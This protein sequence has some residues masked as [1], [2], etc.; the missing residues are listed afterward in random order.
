VKTEYVRKSGLK[1]SVTQSRQPGFPPVYRGREIMPDGFY[2]EFLCEHASK[3]DPAD[4]DFVFHGDEDILAWCIAV[5]QESPL[6]RSLIEEVIATGWAF[7][8]DDLNNGGFHLDVERRLCRVDH[9]SLTP[10]ALSRSS[11]FRNSVLVSFVRALRDI[12]HED[13]IGGIESKLAPE[14]LIVLERLRS[15]DGDTVALFAGWELKGAGHADVW[16]YII[17]SD[18][19]DLAMVFSRFLERGAAALSGGSALIY[20]FRQWFADDL[21]VNSCDHD[22]LEYLDEIL[23]NSPERNPFG[24]NLLNGALAE[25]MSRLPDGTVYLRGFGESLVCDPFYAGMKDTVNQKHFMHLMRDMEVT[26]VQNVPF[27]DEKLARMI[28]PESEPETANI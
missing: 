15:A 28:F 8:L 9:H 27:R 21:R 2:L 10:L 18:E 17:G 25:S 1:K 5:L 19:G 14:A 6:A 20:A 7:C 26:M 3:I 23:N 12:W 24:E 16:R 22:T 13:R 4:K 11:Y